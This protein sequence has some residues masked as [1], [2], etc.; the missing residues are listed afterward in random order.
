MAVKL[1]HWPS[2]LSKNAEEQEIRNWLR[3][4]GEKVI[5]W[6][7]AIDRGRWYFNIIDYLEMAVGRPHFSEKWEVDTPYVGVGLYRPSE[8]NGKP[9]NKTR[10]LP[11]KVGRILL[12][13]A[14]NRGTFLKPTLYEYLRNPHRQTIELPDTEWL[15]KHR[16]C[17]YH[18]H[19]IVLERLLTLTNV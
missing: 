16:K 10:R 1:G 19:D 4:K 12:K 3:K 9:P 18:G 15:G 2:P 17:I 11:A 13:I 8:T 7:K 14:S 5:R 6:Y